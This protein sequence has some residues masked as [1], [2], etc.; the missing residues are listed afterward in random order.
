MPGTWFRQAL[1]A[2]DQRAE[3]VIDDFSRLPTVAL[4]LANGIPVIGVTFFEWTLFDVLL[5]YWCESAVIGSWNLA[6]MMVIGGWRAGPMGLFFCVHYGVFMA[7]HLIFIH[8]LFGD[9]P[10]VG[11]PPPGLFADTAN[12]TLPVLALVV[13]HGIAFLW[14]FIGRREYVERDLQELMIAPYGRVVALHATLLGGGWVIETLGSSTAIVVVL[15]V[16]KVGID[17]FMDAREYH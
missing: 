3:Q 12:L 10:F 17:T 1:K 8:V 2:L 16:T 11:D 7:V 4:I 15:I 5:I 6:R 9:D 14:N 13:S